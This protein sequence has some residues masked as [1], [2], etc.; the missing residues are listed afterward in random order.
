MV[1]TRVAPS[2]LVAP[3]ST[4]YA[5]EYHLVRVVIWISQHIARFFTTPDYAQLILGPWAEYAMTQAYLLWG[6]DRFVNFVEVLSMFGSAIGVSVI[7][8]ILGA[9]PRGQVLAAVI[10]A[11]IPSGVLEASGPMN[12][13]VVSFW[14]T[15]T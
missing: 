7:A 1:M 2:A 14:I 9:G 3:P 10:C 5:M 15:T 8:K 12:T 4:W 13:Y 6:T 11:T